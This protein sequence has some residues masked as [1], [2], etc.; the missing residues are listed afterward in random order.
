MD[1]TLR[2]ILVYTHNSIGLGHAVRTMAVIDGLRAA[3]PGADFLAI[4]GTSAPQIFLSEGIEIVK[5]PGIRRDL[6]APGTPYRSRLLRTLDLREVSAWRERLIRDCLEGFGPDAVLVEHSLAGLM[7]EALPILAARYAGAPFVLAHLSRGIYRQEPCLLAPAADCPGLPPGLHLSRLYDRFYVMEE[8][9]V[10]DVNR[11]YY[12]G[13]P[14]VEDRILYLGRIAACNAGERTRQDEVMASLGLSGR[15]FFLVSL[16]RH[17]LVAELHRTIVGALR[18]V[19]AQAGRDILV[20]PDPYLRPDELAEVRALVR[21]AGARVLPFV[22]R[23]AGLVA[24]ADLVIC[25]AG[26]NTIN[27]ILLSGVP[28]LVIPERHP[29]REQERRAAGLAVGNLLVR[30]EDA[31]LAQPP[32]PWLHDLLGCGP[33]AVKFDFDR[34]RIGRAMAADLAMLLAERARKC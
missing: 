11:E 13:D 10:V 4:S 17:G 19:D 9:A 33:G 22:P 18:R 7:D 20:A 23:L 29:S 32:D 5:L 31:V 1:H 12:G 14:V 21:E 28:A 16:G 15:P 3:L 8:R 27:D 24:A 30:D 25:R 6:E 34:F 2:R 26:Y